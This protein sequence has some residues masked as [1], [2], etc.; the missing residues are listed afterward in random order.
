MIR[1]RSKYGDVPVASPADLFVVPT[2]DVDVEHRRLGETLIE[3][4][5]AIGVAKG[6]D[7]EAGRERFF[8]RGKGA[9]T[10]PVRDPVLYFVQ[11]LRDGRARGLGRDRSRDR[12]GLRPA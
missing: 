7:R 5:V 12:W 3:V 8:A 1:R 10:L 2:E 11:R 9:F 4:V 6:Q